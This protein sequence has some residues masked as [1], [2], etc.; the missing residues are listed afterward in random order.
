M[1]G[2]TIKEFVD[3]H[4]IY[5]VSSLIYELTEEGKID[6][7]YSQLWQGSIDWDAAD[8]YITDRN[9]RVVEKDG[10]WLVE[11]DSNCSD[12]IDSEY[13]SKEEAIAAYF[14]DDLSDF[15]REV[16]EHWIVT[17]S[18]ARRLEE[19]GETVTKFYGLTIWSRTTT[20]QVIAMDYVIEKIYQDVI[21]F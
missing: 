3:V 11:Y 9:C 1:S 14:D 6:E 8:D 21:N 10:Y 4:I 12:I 19:K 17:S 18:L 20:G 15:E 13:N 5:C 7:E 16:F 2:L